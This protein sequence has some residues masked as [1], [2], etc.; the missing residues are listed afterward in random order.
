MCTRKSKNRSDHATFHDV[1]IHFEPDE[2][3]EAKRRRLKNP[4]LFI[5]HITLFLRERAIITTNLNY[6]VL[7][8]EAHLQIISTVRLCPP[9]F[10]WPRLVFRVPSTVVRGG[11]PQ[12]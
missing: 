6:K 2:K 10:I 8:R 12:M 1:F 9:C 7:I 4:S 3:K 11:L 5:T